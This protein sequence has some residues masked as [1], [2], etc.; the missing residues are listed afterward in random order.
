MIVRMMKLLLL[1]LSFNLYAQGG[2]FLPTQKTISK[3]FGLPVRI[4]LDG[5]IQF[6][7][8][9]RDL[10]FAPGVQLGFDK[11]FV[12][13]S[14]PEMASEFSLMPPRETAGWVEYK[15]IHYDLGMGLLGIMKQRVR[16]GFAPYKGAKLSMRRLKIDK[17]LITAN[18]VIPKKLADM[19]NWSVGDQGNFQT[20][21]GI[22]LY[23]GLDA[24]PVNMAMATLGWQNQFIVTIEREETG[25]KL[26]ITEEKLNRKTFDLGFEAVNGNW[27]QF[28]GKQLHASFN[29]DF[30]NPLHHDL[31]KTALKG[32]LNILE[33]NLPTDKKNVKWVGNDFSL[34]WGIPWFYGHTVS[35]GS[36][37]V[38]EDV[39][40]Y[41]LEVFQNK[42]SGILVP[43]SFHQKFVYHNSE[44]L[45]LMW[46]TDVK[47]SSPKSLNKFFF[48]PART[49][50][51]PGFE[52][53]L[54]L[55]EYGTVIGEV[56]VV[57]T[58][59]DVEKFNSLEASS[60]ESSLRA[61]CHELKLG[62]S[63]ESKLRKIVNKFTFI[64]KNEW[65]MKKKGLGILLVKEPALLH[66]LLKES[67][68]TKEAYFKFL[69]DR[70]Q[71]LEGLTV[72]DF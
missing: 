52:I 33:K 66:A 45:L 56:G 21:G 42:K 59:E 1:L 40:D 32:E 15:R 36:Y 23:V 61:R 29:L 12:Q 5:N 8:G 62:C 44:S 24:G 55:K 64:M 71:S 11:S 49:I 46:T 10:V 4:D 14:I 26:I 3:P 25:V 2:D 67:A 27:T 50:G 16:L 51:F 47:E 53:D 19:E 18:I 31:Y 60:V 38:K 39:Q 22:Q 6:L 9:N 28:N 70:Y 48:G 7:T 13:Y 20:Y 43:T 57:I 41:F 30:A 35:R 37:K 17:A 69:S 65:D 72:L 58:K 34:Y 54:N 63:Q 68:L